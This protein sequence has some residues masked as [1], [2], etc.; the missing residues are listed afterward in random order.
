[1]QSHTAPTTAVFPETKD[2]GAGSE[3]VALQSVQDIIGLWPR[4]QDLADE[5]GVTLVR[6]HGW[7]TTGSI[8]ARYHRGLVLAARK[9]GWDVVTADL[10]DALHCPSMTAPEAAE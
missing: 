8:P 2:T 10:V 5:L 4:R 1:M 9:R 7:A 6:V 3:A